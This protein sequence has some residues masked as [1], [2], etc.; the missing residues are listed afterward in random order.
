ML[1]QADSDSLGKFLSDLL[2]SNLASTSY[3][4]PYTGIVLETGEVVDIKV[5]KT[6]FL[7]S[8]NIPLCERGRPINC[9]VVFNKQREINSKQRGVRFIKIH[10][11][12][13]VIYLFFY[14]SV[15]HIQYI[16]CYIHIGCQLKV[17]FK[18][19]MKG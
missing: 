3:G 12:T 17:G 9:K 5:N 16:V 8:E 14:V 13:L 11:Y 15:T 6:H 4:L 7:A 18:I 19:K 2:N 10:C 1:A